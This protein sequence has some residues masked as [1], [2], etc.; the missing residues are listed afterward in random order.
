M[1]KG[2]KHLTHKKKLR[3][4]KL[5]SLGQGSLRENLTNGY[6]YLKEGYTEDKV[7]LLSVVPNDRTR[8]NGR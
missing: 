3:L 5:F 4:L 2:L 8:D 7:R 1:M 6:K